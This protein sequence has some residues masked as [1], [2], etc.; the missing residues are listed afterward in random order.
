LASN[1]VLFN[2]PL[3]FYDM[4]VS[5][6]KKNVELEAEPEIPRRFSKASF[7]LQLLI[8]RH[9]PQLTND[10]I[11]KCGWLLLVSQL[12]AFVALALFEP[13]TQYRLFWL[14]W[15]F[16]VLGIVALSSAI[17]IVLVLLFAGDAFPDHYARIV[18]SRERIH[19]ITVDG[20]FFLFVAEIICVA[21]ITTCVA[22]LDPTAFE[23]L[24]YPPN[25]FELAYFAIVTGFTVGY[26]DIAPHSWLAR[27]LSVIQIFITS[28][29]VIGLAGILVSSYVTSLWN[30]RAYLDA[31]SRHHFHEPGIPAESPPANQDSAVNINTINS[32]TP[33]SSQKRNS[34]GEEPV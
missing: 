11:H 17:V 10:R 30:R 1:I 9:L 22:Y 14:S 16:T 5:M 15:S 26:G 19:P 29:M 34:S 13:C 24:R 4:E 8:L 18:N 32:G 28:L 12:P 27:G 21:N 2:L 3:E 23:G 6:G 20:F 25:V 7:K 33:E 31:V